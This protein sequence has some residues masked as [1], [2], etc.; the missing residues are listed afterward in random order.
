ML[1]DYNGTGYHV[2]QPSDDSSRQY[3]E[4]NSNQESEIRY[5]IDIL[6]AHGWRYEEEL[7]TSPNQ[8]FVYAK[9]GEES[10]SL[11]HR[12]VLLIALENKAQLWTA[13]LEAI[14]AKK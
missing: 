11:G 4:L 5:V 3:M 14:G 7:W 2:W 10:L 8:I 13:I 1:K 12:P 9:K 6:A